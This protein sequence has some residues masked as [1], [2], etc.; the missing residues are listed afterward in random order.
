MGDNGAITN[1][2]NNLTRVTACNG[3]CWDGVNISS[4]DLAS[5]L[6]WTGDITGII[7]NRNYGIT[8][9]EDT[10]KDIVEKITK[11]RELAK[12]TPDDE[13]EIPKWTGFLEI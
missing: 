5:N 10:I 2:L 9:N 8:L 1:N 7:S 12:I 4:E 6:V 3:Y 13:L 11:E